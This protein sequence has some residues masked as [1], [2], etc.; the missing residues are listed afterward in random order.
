MAAREYR[1]IQGDAWDSIAYRL[2]GE[3][4]YM[5][6]IIAA[7]PDHADILIFPAG[8]VLALPDVDVSARPLTTLPPWVTP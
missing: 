1:A 8:V 2:W 3:E 5:A 7:N 4:R 6:D